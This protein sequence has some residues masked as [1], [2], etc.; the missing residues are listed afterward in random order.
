MSDAPSAF[1]EGAFA[2]RAVLI[3]RGSACAYS[4]KG[5]GPKAG[6]RGWLAFAEGVGPVAPDG[7]VVGGGAVPAGVL[8][9]VYV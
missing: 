9:R 6:L 5:D 1:P 3:S 4:P 8:F 7:D 2:R